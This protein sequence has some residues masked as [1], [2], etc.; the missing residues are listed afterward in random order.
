MLKYSRIRC[1]C[2]IKENIRRQNKLWKRCIMVNQQCKSEIEKILNI[3]GRR[4]NE[5]GIHWAVGGSCLLKVYGIVDQVGDIDL[6]F[7]YQDITQVLLIMDEICYRKE[8]P[9]KSEYETAAFYVYECDQISIDIMANF[10]IKHEDGVYEFI[11]DDQSIVY[12]EELYGVEIPYTSLED[13]LV[14]YDVMI[15]RESKVKMIKD[16]FISHPAV[17]R[18]L[19]E[20]NREQEIPAHTKQLINEILGER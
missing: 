13:W 17:H 18:T 16:Y 5:V 8:I 20:R 14:A 15:N 7:A 10:R 1:Q 19:L 6:L 4:F 3:L 2:C 9:I 11:F 12:R